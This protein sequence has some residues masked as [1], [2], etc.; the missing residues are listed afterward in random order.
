[1]FRSRETGW[2]VRSLDVIHAGA[3]IC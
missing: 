2:G 3:F 1:V